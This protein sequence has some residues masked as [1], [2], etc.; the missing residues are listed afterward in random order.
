MLQLELYIAVAIVLVVFHSG[1]FL[2]FGIESGIR[3]L[4]CLYSL[5]RLRCRI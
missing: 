2:A 4:M 3:R 5:S 1:E